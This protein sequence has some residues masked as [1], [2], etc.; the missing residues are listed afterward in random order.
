[1]PP[2]DSDLEEHALVYLH[3]NLPLLFRHMS[4]PSKASLSTK[5]HPKKP[6]RETI[7]EENQRKSFSTITNKNRNGDTSDARIGKSFPMKAGKNVVKKAAAVN[8]SGFRFDILNEDVNVRS[9][10]KDNGAV[11][12]SMADKTQSNKSVLT[13][14]TNQKCN[15]G[16]KMSIKKIIRKGEVTTPHISGL[17]KSVGSQGEASCLKSKGGRKGKYQVHEPYAQVKSEIPDIEVLRQFHKEVNSFETRSTENNSTSDTTPSLVAW[18]VPP[19]INPSAVRPLKQTRRSPP[20]PQ[21]DTRRESVS[22]QRTPP[23]SNTRRESEEKKQAAAA[24]EEKK[25]EEAKKAEEEKKQETKPAEEK[26]KEAPEESKEA[27]ETKEEPAPPPPPPPQ[28]IVLKVYMHCEGCARKVR[29]C[30]KGFPGVESAESDLKSSEVTV[31][32]AFD[33]PKLV[34]YVY[35]RTGK[36]G[37]IVKQEPEK[38][39][40]KAEEANKQEQKKGSEEGG[41]KEKEKEKEKENKAIEEEKKEG[42]GEVAKPSAEATTEEAK[43][44][45]LKINEYNHYPAIYGIAMEM[46]PYPPQPQ[47][48][49][50]YPPQMLSPYAPQMFSDE[51]PNACSVM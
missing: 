51:N 20:I 49:S 32:G 24:A 5:F 6:S 16:E 47:M 19:V 48:W 8:G 34:E 42:G 12:K 11:S 40:E 30:L 9:V 17:S 4:L 37:V 27:K 29:R 18:V 25:P 22:R 15:K 23:H 28:E 50:S 46:N 45:E 39:E 2:H 7:Y 13:D 36:H 14:I 41:E 21:S 35:K 26:K 44:A 33:P 31:K 1:M 3:S 10:E 43:V 38:K